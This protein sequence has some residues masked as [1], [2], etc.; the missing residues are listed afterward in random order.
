MP[1]ASTTTMTTA[2]PTKTPQSCTAWVPTT[3]S[4]AERTL[5]GS[6]KRRSSGV[7]SSDVVVG[8]RVVDVGVVDSKV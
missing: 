6:A 7:E 4:T 3:S 8:S 5:S 1:E 2:R